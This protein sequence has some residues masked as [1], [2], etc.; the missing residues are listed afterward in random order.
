MNSVSVVIPN[1]NGRQLLERYLP[2]VEI[3]LRHP[4]VSASEIIVSDDCSTDDS[5][6]FLHKNYPNVIVIESARNEGFA[7]TS[8]RGIARATM[9]Y[10]L[11]LNSDMQLMPDTIGVLLAH[12]NNE[13]FGVS[14]A[15]CDP[16]DGHI[17]EGLKKPHIRGSKIG[18]YDDL[19]D[20]AEGET[21][22]LCGGLALMDRAKLNTLGGY[23]TLYAPFYFEDMDLSLRAKQQG[24]ISWYTSATKAIHQHSATIGSHF[25]KEEVQAVFIRNR[26]WISWRFMPKRHLRIAFNT[27]FHALQELFSRSAFRP[28]SEALKRLFCD[29]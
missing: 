21:M 9:D 27:A 8:N 2:A 16:H 20:Q 13:L 25:T 12:M 28:Y 6:A 14:C 29:K 24:W 5:V 26:V 7:P 23:D 3:A 19:S 11:M 18:Y 4:S 17:Q 15:I 1:F 22:Y 10:V